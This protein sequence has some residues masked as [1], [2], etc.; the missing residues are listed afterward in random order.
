VSAR[1]PCRRERCITQLRRLRAGVWIARITRA[2]VSCRVDVGV[3]VVPDDAN[4]VSASVKTAQG[5]TSAKN[6]QRRDVRRNSVNSPIG[7]YPIRYMAGVDVATHVPLTTLTRFG[8]SFDKQKV[9][10]LWNT[11]YWGPSS[12]C[13]GRRGKSV[14]QSLD[15][16]CRCRRSVVTQSMTAGASDGGAG[17]AAQAA[18][19]RGAGTGGGGTGEAGEAVRRR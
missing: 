17:A 18:V 12:H 19:A 11:R 16:L 3:D 4:L 7:V 9:L 1:T 15:G 13:C 6:A 10:T 14:G 2:V 5:A 8:A